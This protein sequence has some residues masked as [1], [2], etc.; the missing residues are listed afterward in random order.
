MASVVA[1]VS[2]RVLLFVGKALDA[3]HGLLFFRY[4]CCPAGVKSR[5]DVPRTSISIELLASAFFYKIVIKIT[6]MYQGVIAS[7]HN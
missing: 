5:V 6:V 1:S 2:I 3:G 4:R 7:Q